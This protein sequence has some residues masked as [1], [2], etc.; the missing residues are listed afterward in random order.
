[1]KLVVGLL[2]LIALGALAGLVYLAGEEKLTD[3]LTTG[4]FGTATACV[5]VIGGLLART[6]SIDVD[7]LDELKAAADESFLPVIADKLA[8]ARSEGAT[9]VLA[10]LAGPADPVNRAG[11]LFA[12]GDP[13]AAVGEGADPAD[14]AV[15]DVE[16]DDPGDPVPPAGAAPLDGIPPPG[17]A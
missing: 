11:V 6:D 1:M 10:Q 8:A 15:P 7:A 3:A 5:G 14:V 17:S 2:G 16:L 12:S 9:Q 13:F 4:L